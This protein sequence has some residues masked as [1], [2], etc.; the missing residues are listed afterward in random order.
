MA[1]AAFLVAL[2]AAT[3]V[4]LAPVDQCAGDASFVAFRDGLT[5]IIAKRDAPAM[6]AALSDDVEVDFGG[7]TGREAFTRNWQLDNPADSPLW[8]KLGAA[9]ALGCAV[10]EEYRI[11][12]SSVVQFDPMLDAYNSVIAGPAGTLHAAPSD[13]AAVVARLSWDVLTLGEPNDAPGWYAAKLADGRVGFVRQ[14]Q[15]R[16]PLDFRIVMKRVGGRW[17]IT[18]F[19][20]GD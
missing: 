13:D 17:A 16:S 19:V 5:A 9:L 10:S 3:T 4:K 18:A 20:G 8:A 14:E 7:G 12:P 1:V 11:A 2:A 6:L 15:V